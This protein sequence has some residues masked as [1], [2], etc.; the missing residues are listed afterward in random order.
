MI[1]TSIARS[2]PPRCFLFTHPC[3]NCEISQSGISHYDGIISDLPRNA[4]S[5]FNKS[6]PPM[7]SP[8]H[9]CWSNRPVGELLSV[10]H[11]RLESILQCRF[12]LFAALQ[13]RLQA[14]EWPWSARAD[15]PP[16][17]AC[18]IALVTHVCLKVGS[19]M[20]SIVGNGHPTTIS[21][22]L[23]PVTS[24]QVAEQST[25]K[26]VQH[27]C[28]NTQPP[29]RQRNQFAPSCRGRS[30]LLHQ[31]YASASLLL[32][33]MTSYVVDLQGKPSRLT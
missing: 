14:A 4:A 26:Q 32:L 9:P 17:Q 33:Q 24:R 18:H 2:R 10:P 23:N 5:A 31:P 6:Q 21:N 13:L 11:Q 28:H 15:R 29:S 7:Q 19:G 20:Q 30:M 27:W 8:C 25:N 16:R 22:T 1:G 12:L 3:S